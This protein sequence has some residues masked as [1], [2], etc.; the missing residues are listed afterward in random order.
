[1]FRCNNGSCLNRTRVCDLTE[2][3]AEGEDEK[4]E[5]GKIFRRCW[6]ILIDVHCEK[7]QQYKHFL[8]IICQDKIPEH[9]RCNFEQDWCGW[10]NM[11]D[12]PLNWTRMQG[13]S[14]KEKTGPSYD[15]TYRNTSGNNNLLLVQSA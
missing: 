14:L 6:R 2:D 7:L 12:R 8:M 15:H 10:T 5:C 1:M 11:T 13:P 4:A 9:A 3:C